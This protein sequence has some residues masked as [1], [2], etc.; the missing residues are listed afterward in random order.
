M[1]LDIAPLIDI[2]FMLLLFFILT[3]N[4]IKPSIPLKLP[5][6]SNKK[7]IE[8]QD[9]MISINDKGKIYFNRE[10]VSI[11]FLEIKLRKAIEKD[12]DQRVIFQGDERILY[13]D[14]VTILD[15]IKSSGV[16]DINIAHDAET[17]K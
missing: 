5:E 2:V 7:K 13:K 14:F 16:K 10:L 17:F 4:F 1:V 3:S 6:A 8:D 15:K 11:D 12:E 9:I